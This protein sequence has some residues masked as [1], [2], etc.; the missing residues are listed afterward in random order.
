MLMNFLSASAKLSIWL[1]RKNQAQNAGSVEPVPV[2]EGRVKARL[3]EGHAY[4]R[5]MNN[6]QAF[7]CLWAV[8]GG[9]VL[10]GR[11]WG[12]GCKFLI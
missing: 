12:L 10:C 7:S 8:G 1:T 11:E 4:D 3:K 9:L 2:L 5:M 6:L